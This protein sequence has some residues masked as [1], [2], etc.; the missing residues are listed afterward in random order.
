MFKDT[1]VLSAITVLELLERATIVGKETFRFLEPLTMV[2]V[3]FLALSLASGY[4][5]RWLSRRFQIAG[6]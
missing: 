5:V 3:I 2:G 6:A 4:L 1:P